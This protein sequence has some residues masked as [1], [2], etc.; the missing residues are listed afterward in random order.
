MR[1]FSCS[2]CGSLLVFE[3]S[4]CVTCGTPQGFHLPDFDVLA[5]PADGSLVPC[6]N[7]ALAGCSW[8]VSA[9]GQLC[10]SCRLTRTRPADDDAVGLAAYARTEAEKRRLIYQL[11]DLNLPVVS[12][13]DDR[14]GLRFDLL[15]SVREKVITGHADG[16][17][18]IDLAEG[19]DPHREAMRVQM[20][21]AYRTMLG[22]LRHETGH[23]YQQVLVD[24]LA[25]AAGWTSTAPRVRPWVA[26]QAS[27]DRY[28]ELF[29]DPGA[30]YAQ[31]LQRH[32]AQGA[33]PDW[34]ASHVSEYA[35]AHPFEDWAETFAHYLHI[36]DTLQSASAYGLSVDGP[37]LPA[38]AVLQAEPVDAAAS[39]GTG[40]DL[41]DRW[42]PISYAL[43]AM[44]RSM[45]ND[46]L[47]PFVLSEP[48]IDK[49]CFVH[50]L[51]VG[52]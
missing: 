12:A 9:P 17:V 36:T 5:V 40:R 4:V 23:Y 27:T 6:A 26:G 2:V 32:Y 34:R 42:L 44:S 33:P 46:D 10:L 19:D 13:E 15:S 52:T 29:G 49:L 47:Y 51:I 18:T 45:G 24:G 14:F 11:V 20:G 38:G 37:A 50:D 16:V 1:T 25:P 48:V 41:V 30:D 21:E 8:L 3:N 35:T 39:L 43:N 28:L 31:A 22:H 7:L